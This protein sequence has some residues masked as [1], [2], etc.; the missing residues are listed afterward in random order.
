MN[1]TSIKDPFFTIKESDKEFD[2]QPVLTNRLDKHSDEFDQSVIN[3]II[4]WKV[5][6][7]ADLPNELIEKLNSIDP[8]D[9]ILDVHI[10]RE[11][12]HDLLQVKGV[13]LAMAS[14]ILRFRNPKV[15][16]IID[17]R[18][19][20]VLYKKQ[21]KVSTSLSK[22][23]V[24]EQVNLYIQYLSDLRKACIQLNINFED[25]DR[26]LYNADKRLNRGVKIKY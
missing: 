16:Q 12:I 9:D 23:K 7:Y 22:A 4:L 1:I 11:I 2:Y 18:V 17:Q 19:F 14:T 26:V 20:R 13:R 6:R 25:A 24:D 21:F 5:N 3:Q 15:Y 10:T 8:T